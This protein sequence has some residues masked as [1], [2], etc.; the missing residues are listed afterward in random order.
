[1]ILMEIYMKQIKQ[2]FL[3]ALLLVSLFSGALSAN[4]LKFGFV[5]RQVLDQDSLYAKDV[6][7]RIKKE[8]EGRQ[9]KLVAREKELMQKFEGLQRDKDVL[10]AKELAKLEKDI[11]TMRTSF[12]SD[13]EELKQDFI[14]RRDKESLAFEKVMKDALAEVAKV[15]KLDTILVNN[16]ALYT[17][18]KSDFTYAALKELDKHYKEN[19]AK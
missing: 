16:A 3:G 11:E 14:R 5:D 6:N 4:E 2:I 7:A 17:T 15:K 9:E 18:S 12:M 10:G 8:F 19:I 1:M 13:N